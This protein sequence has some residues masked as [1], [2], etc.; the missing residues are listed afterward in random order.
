M[1]IFKATGY[2]TEGLMEYEFLIELVGALDDIE[3]W[4]YAARKAWLWFAENNCTLST[5]EC[6]AC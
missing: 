6:I 1:T 3:I 4:E 5:L 2:G